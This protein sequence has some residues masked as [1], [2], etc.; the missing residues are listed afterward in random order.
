MPERVRGAASLGVGLHLLG[1]WFLLHS[2]AAFRADRLPVPA[3]HRIDLTF[4]AP[5]AALG[6]RTTP[7]PSDANREASAPVAAPEPVTR[8]RAPT[9]ASLIPVLDA[10][11]VGTDPASGAPGP[12]ELF[13]GLFPSGALGNPSGV[14]GGLFD[15]VVG[16]SIHGAGARED[17]VLPPP[18]EPPAPISLP[19]PRFPA[20]ALRDGVR[21]EVVLRAVI[22]ARGAVEVLRVLQSVPGLDEEAIR[23]VEA[24]W[25]FQ[26]AQRNGRPTPALSDLAVRFSLR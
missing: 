11:D 25:R 26:P 16:G 24:E 15:G 17:P 7:L 23:V 18:D 8:E 19:R 14:T 22:T 10:F 2:S 4:P 12:D 13:A 3:A 1:F 21:G 5:A 6:D 9:L 20:E